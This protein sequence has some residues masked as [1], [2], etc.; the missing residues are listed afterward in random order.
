M[1][2]D[3]SH[4]DGLRR[5]VGETGIRTSDD[6]KGLDPGTD[7]ENFDCGVLIRPS[8]VDEVS[9]VLA[10]CN[11][12]VI[13]VVTQGGRT[14]LAMG[15]IS[16][17]GEIAIETSLLDNIISLD[18]IAGTAVVEAGVTLE[19]I[20]KAANEHGLSV[21]I[22]LSARGS[23]T[24]GGMVSTN[25]GGIE[26]FRN[27]ITRHR[28][29]GLQAI[30][31]DGKILNELKQVTK[32]NEGIDIKQLFI[33]AEGTLGIVTQICL[34]L[35]PVQHNKMTALVSVD[36]PEDA[37]TVYRN[38]RNR[39]DGQLLSAEMMLPAYARQAA[40]ELDRESTLAFESDTKATFAL[41]EVADENNSGVRF[42][43]DVLEK[44]IER[45]SVRNAVVAKNDRERDEMWQLREESFAAE[46]SYPHQLW[47]DVSVPLGRFQEYLDQVTKEI[48]QLD[49]SL[50]LFIIAHIGDGNIHTTVAS[51]QSLGPIEDE[52]R[53]INYRSLT[54]MGGSFSAEHG[55]GLE[56]RRYL[57]K[58]A[59]PRKMSLMQSIKHTF[60]PAGIM[61]P[62]KML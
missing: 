47:F 36:T 22:D 20:E 28:V 37:I 8:T 60:D 45:G 26:A 43:E 59:C 58:Y 46:A 51:M 10:Y 39:R 30:L 5:I 32:A 15:A 19:K 18:P 34:N 7:H 50:A 4:I 11:E 17:P 61:N 29:V 13:G 55:I 21:G 2:I 53:H 1:T 23:A 56:K 3:S 35:V 27:G 33:G 24:V 62:G 48:A 44:C 12:H 9:R 54:D 52:V 41:F 40:K 49:P 6:L 31:A 57:A 14:G 16:K 38:F 25:A 42:L